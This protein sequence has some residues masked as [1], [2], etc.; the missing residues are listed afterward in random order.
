MYAQE[1]A[2]Y[3]LN[4]VLCNPGL[5]INGYSVC[6]RPLSEGDPGYPRG[7]GAN[8]PGGH[9]YPEFS[10]NLH[11]IERILTPRGAHI[12]NFTMYYV[13]AYVYGN[14]GAHKNATSLL[15]DKF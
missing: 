13:T 3:M 10:Q 2:Q 5:Y 1:V 7:G 9:Q 15:I 11:E 4:D 12:Q 14:K 8:L 6:V